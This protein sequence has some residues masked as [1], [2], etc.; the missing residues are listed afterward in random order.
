MEMPPRSRAIATQGASMKIAFYAPMKPPTAVSPSGDRTIGR[1][2]IEALET[3][4]FDVEVASSLR[5][6]S[7][8]PDPAR[9]AAFRNAAA[10]EQER[11]LAA[12]RGLSADRQPDLWFTY[13]NYYKAP[14]FL[15]PA[16]ADALGIPY[17]VV[18]ASYAAHRAKGPWADWLEEARRGI[19]AADL[20]FSF[21]Q[22]DE[23][24]LKPISRAE[25]RRRLAPFL[26]EL[27][28]ARPSGS[29][30]RSGAVRLICVA[31]MR[32]GAKAESY[33][34]LAAAL[35]NLM[36]QDWTLDVVGDGVMRSELQQLFSAAGGD[37]VCFRGRLEGA[38]L[39]EALNDADIFVW[40]GIDET[41][42]MAFLEAQA[43]GL[44]VAACDTAGV[45]EVVRHG[46]TGLLARETTPDALAATIAILIRSP[47]LRWKLGNQA[48][49]H[50][51][52]HHSIGSAAA[53]L[54]RELTALTA[55]R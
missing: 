2:L 8:T 30:E 25:R 34:L 41:F 20:I 36:H 17:V 26:G 22:R 12:W 16:V 24:G 4:R 37:R 35:G 18:E 1:L 55:R 14:D 11:V 51:A 33:R 15:G 53:M 29:S 6:W 5:T 43:F 19:A 3:A 9:L 45:D 13:H 54:G 27:P 28:P 38:A 49:D 32:E 44:P 42:G 50:I 10:T 47:D 48:R 46:Q 23:I 7:G 39:T 31:M 52:A 21:T 40:P